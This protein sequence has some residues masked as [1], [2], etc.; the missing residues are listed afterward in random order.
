MA[1]RH[2]DRER[3]RREITADL[4]EDLSEGEKGDTVGDL[5]AP[6]ENLKGKMRR[7]SSIDVMANWAT[8]QKE[9]KLYIVLI[10]HES[11]FLSSLFI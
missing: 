7:V 1:K 4:S 8:Q 2:S 6:A 3:G 10:R 11:N 5:P 9:K